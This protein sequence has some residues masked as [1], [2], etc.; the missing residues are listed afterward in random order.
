MLIASYPSIVRTWTFS[1]DR[2]SRMPDRRKWLGF[3]GMFGGLHRRTNGA[4]VNRNKLALFENLQLELPAFE[5]HQHV[6]EVVPR[7]FPAI[8]NEE[9]QPTILVLVPFNT[10]AAHLGSSPQS[11]ASLLDVLERQ[12]APNFLDQPVR[13]ERED[14]LRGRR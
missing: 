12:R 7:N 1:P 5:G 6:A 11:K 13:T 8:D 2:G 3:L 4:G 9:W 10:A 14:P